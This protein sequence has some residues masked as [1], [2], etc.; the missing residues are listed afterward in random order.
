MYWL[1]KDQDKE[2]LLKGRTMKYCAEQIGV[3]RTYL[4]AILNHWRG[5]SKFVAFCITKYFDN[6]KE[7]LEMFDDD[8]KNKE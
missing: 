1:K 5:C 3:G 4:S 8:R 2:E 7:V 6:E